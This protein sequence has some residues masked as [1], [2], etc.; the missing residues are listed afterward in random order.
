M[1]ERPKWMPSEGY[2]R[3]AGPDA[4]RRYR[5]TGLRARLDALERAVQALSSSV[6]P[7]EQQVGAH[8]A[9]LERLALAGERLD[10]LTSRV[11]MLASRP[12]PVACVAAL[13][14]GAGRVPLSCRLQ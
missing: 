8:G 9:E 2:L 4:E 5:D 10:A 3:V 11:D 14:L 6:P 13:N 7:L 12:I 1:T